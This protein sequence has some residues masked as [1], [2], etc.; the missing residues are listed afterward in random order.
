MRRHSRRWTWRRK[1]RAHSERH[2]VTWCGVAAGVHEHPAHGDPE[3]PGPSSARGTPHWHTPCAHPAGLQAI[4]G[5]LDK[6]R[7]TE[8]QERGEGTEAGPGRGPQPGEGDTARGKP[9]E[10][11]EGGVSINSQPGTTERPEAR[12]RDRSRERRRGSHD[13]ERERSRS[14][15]HRQARSRSGHR[16]RQKR[17]RSR[18]YRQRR[19]RSVRRE[20]RSRYGVWCCGRRGDWWGWLQVSE[21]V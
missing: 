8:L 16:R 2:G 3:A 13:R 5:Y 17:S 12:G 20:R 1:R 6:R 19:S 11:P 18:S 10:R 14:R 15:G 4:D 9:S 7:K 21:T